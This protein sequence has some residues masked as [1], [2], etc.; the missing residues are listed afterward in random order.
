MR[1]RR[2]ER[3]ERGKKEEGREAEEEEDTKVKKD[4]TDWT[5]VT[6]NREPEEDD[7]TFVKVNES[8]AI[9][10]EVSTDDKVDDVI[11]RIPNGEDM[12]VTMHGRSAEEKREAEELRSY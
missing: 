4:V 12:Y 2:E 11:R 6:R 7:Q 1:K 9:P 10:L 3:C 5:V 8:K